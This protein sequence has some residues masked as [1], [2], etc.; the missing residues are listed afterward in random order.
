M[1]EMSGLYKQTLQVSV[2]LAWGLHLALAT[3][4]LPSSP[5]Q[6]CVNGVLLLLVSQ[7]PWPCLLFKRHFCHA[8]SFL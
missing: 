6:V 8:Q 5:T 7:V 2:L 4:Q 3:E 1:A